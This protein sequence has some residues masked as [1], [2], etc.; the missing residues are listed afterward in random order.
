MERGNPPIDSGTLAAESHLGVN[1]KGKIDGRRAFGKPLHVTFRREDEDLVLVEVDLEKLEKFFGG[2]CSL[3]QLDELP[4]PREALV[5]LVWL[6]SFL[7][8][9]MRRDAELGGA[10]HLPRANLNFVQLTARTEDRGVQR[11]VAV[12]FGRRDVILDALLQRCPLMVDHAEHVVAI[13][14]FLDQH[15]DCHQ[16]VYLLE[17]LVP[18]F[19]FAV[20]RPQVLRPAGHLELFDTGIGER[21]DERHPK[22]VDHFLALSAFR[23]EF[24]GQGLVVLCFE[25]LER[26]ILQIRFDPRHAEAVGQGCVQLLGFSCDAF[27]PV[28]RQVLQGAHVVEAIGE[29]Y[30]DD[31]RILRDG[32]QQLPVVLNLFFRAGPKVEAGDLG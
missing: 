26:E 27:P 8:Y 15:P 17:R 19:H 32:E 1:R 28:C 14:N 16:V 4:E 5:Q 22:A 30:D 7:I 10:V 6:F 18:R 25:E 11:L 23:P 3:L 24:L 31:P 20:N 13:L 2:M 12:R 29:L 21:L 9:P